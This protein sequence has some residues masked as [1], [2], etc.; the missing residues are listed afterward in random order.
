MHCKACDKSLSETEITWNNELK[1]WELCGTCLS[2]AMD[3]A[4]PS[5]EEEYQFLPFDD[6]NDE[7]EPILFVGEGEAY[8]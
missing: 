3:A 7:E 2:I 1:D 4:Y 6:I 5:D 8:D